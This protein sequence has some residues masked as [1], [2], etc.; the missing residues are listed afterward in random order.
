MRLN[1]SAAS[2][3]LT[4]MRN[5]ESVV[6]F[7]FRLIQEFQRMREKYEADKTKSFNEEIKQLAKEAKKCIVYDDGFTSCR[8]LVQNIEDF[9]HSEASVKENL[10]KKGWIKPVFK[11]VKA[12]EITENGKKSGVLKYDN[13]KTIVYDMSRIQDELNKIHEQS[14]LPIPNSMMIHVYNGF[15][16]EYYTTFPSLMDAQMELGV[17]GISGILNG[18]RGNNKKHI[19]GMCFRTGDIAPKSI[20]PLTGSELKKIFRDINVFDK[21]GVLVGRYKTTLDAGNA[22]GNGKTQVIRLLKSGKQN[23]QGYTYSYAELDF[24]PR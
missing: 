4:L 14:R 20:E 23:Q 16:G 21:D 7:K 2:F 6:E 18:T 3:L 8:E 15:T 1:E 17:T 12:L 19:R 5:T 24:L 22:G 9:N 10:Y 13:H 11:N